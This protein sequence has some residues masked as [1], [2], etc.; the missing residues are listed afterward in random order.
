MEERVFFKKKDLIIVAVSFL[1]M[2]LVG[3]LQDSVLGTKAEII[4]DGEVVET[5]SLN[6]N[7]SISYNAHPEIVFEVL[8]SKIRFHSSDCPD[9]ICVNTGFIQYLGE[10]AAC[11]P[12]KMII[13]IIKG[14][15]N[16]VDAVSK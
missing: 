14:A 1:T 15:E 13:R 16:P 11:L 2:F 5:L 8:D 10:S 3:F 6:K 7:L 4:Y 12:N 9:K